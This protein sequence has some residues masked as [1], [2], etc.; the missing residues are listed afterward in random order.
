MSKTNK[1]IVRN[2]VIRALIDQGL[3]IRLASKTFVP[4]KGR[5]SKYDRKGN[6]EI[7]ND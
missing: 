7:E 3:I 1:K 6:K 2:G 5:G 4:R